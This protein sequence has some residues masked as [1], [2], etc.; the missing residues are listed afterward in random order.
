LVAVELQLL[1]HGFSWLHCV[2]IQ[3]V[4]RAFSSDQ[5]RVCCAG[6]PGKVVFG[7]NSTNSSFSGASEQVLN[8]G[9]LAPAY[10]QGL[11]R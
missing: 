7:T 5:R 9:V 3:W 2:A 8:S 11:K 10:L 4:I 6:V 1:V